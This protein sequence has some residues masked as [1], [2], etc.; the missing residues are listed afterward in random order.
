MESI[1]QNQYTDGAY[2]SDYFINLPMAEKVSK[3]CL[4][5]QSILNWSEGCK[6]NYRYP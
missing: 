4:S 6:V 5:F 1:T 3:E 2:K